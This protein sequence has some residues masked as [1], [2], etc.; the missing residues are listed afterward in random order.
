MIDIGVN[1]TNKQLIPQ[2]QQILKRALEAGVSHCILTGTDL[3][4]SKRSLTLCQEMESALTP[5]LYCT[6]GVHPHN[7]D[8]WKV[9][10]GQR[11]EQL[12]ESP[13]V[14][15][16]GETGLD[17]NR[18]FS[19]KENQIRVFENRLRCQWNAANLC[20]CMSEMPLPAR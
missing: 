17:F 14:V 13:R 19:S 16:V 4:S 12:L 2:A 6:A 10:D 11:L 1:L 18:N 9:G 7:A 15:A 20:S 3:D 8:T 5:K